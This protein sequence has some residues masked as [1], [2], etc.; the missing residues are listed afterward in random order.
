M[1][2]TPF[3]SRLRGRGARTSF[4][5]MHLHRRPFEPRVRWMLAALGVAAWALS[6]FGCAS[7]SRQAPTFTPYPTNSPTA[8]LP[9][10]P[11]T[12]ASGQASPYAIALDGTDLFWSTEGDSAVWRMPTSGGTPQQ[13]YSGSAPSHAIAL[14][15]SFLYVAMAGNSP[16]YPLQKIPRSGGTPTPI[17]QTG[18]VAALATDGSAAYWTEDTAGRV[19]S[20]PVA[21]GTP[22]PLALALSS[23]AGIAVD[24][25]NFYWAEYGGGRVMQEPK[26][27]GTPFNLGIYQG[28]WGVQALGGY[29]YWIEKNGGNLCRAMSGNPIPQVL[30]GGLVS[31][32]YVATDGSTAY[33]AER[34]GGTIGGVSIGSSPSITLYATAQQDPLQLA[35][36]TTYIYWTEHNGGR[37]WRVQRQ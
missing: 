17:A 9:P 3:A 18:S 33:W 28:P 12:I 24:G 11:V 1:Q 25:S 27:A 8:T 29:V 37:V 10:Q 5:G 19:V 20:V 26:P 6:P 34:T 32:Q 4:V 21:G 35:F 36:D 14:D 31:A 15:A 16:P 23:P 13:V 7:T 22:T 30:T 2:E